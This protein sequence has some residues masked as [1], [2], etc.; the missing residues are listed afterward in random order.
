MDTFSARAPATYTTRGGVIVSQ[1]GFIGMGRMG[2][3]MSHRILR[4]SEHQVVVYDA[5]R[6]A[7]RQAVAKRRRRRHLRWPT[8]SSAWIRRARCG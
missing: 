4:D 3:G 8:S 2:G 7:V 5:D 6:D 1:I